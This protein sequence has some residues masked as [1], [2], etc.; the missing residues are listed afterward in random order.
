MFRE[1]ELYGRHN[2]ETFMEFITDLH[3]KENPIEVLLTE[4][5]CSFLI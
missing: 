1:M 4:S 5:L 2:V 3:H